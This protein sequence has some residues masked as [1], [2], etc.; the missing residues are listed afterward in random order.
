MPKILAQD[1]KIESRG[2]I[3]SAVLVGVLEVQQ[4][5]EVAESKEVQQKVRSQSPRTLFVKGLWDVSG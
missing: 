3:G 2:S 4:K 1:P 5:N